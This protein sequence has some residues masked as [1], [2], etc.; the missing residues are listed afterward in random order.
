[1]DT[2]KNEM[3]MANARP[4]ARGPNANYIPLAGVGCSRLGI[5]CSKLRVGCSKLRVGIP[6]AKFL[7]WGLDQCEAPTQRVLHCS[8]IHALHF[9]GRQ[10]DV[11]SR[12]ITQWV[13]SF[14]HLYSYKTP[15]KIH[16]KKLLCLS[17]VIFHSSLC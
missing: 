5:G 15:T 11:R 1:M 14:T 9:K 4:N 7:R 10:N 8:G 2:E 6:N 13:H 12:C 17:I 16:R 3:Y